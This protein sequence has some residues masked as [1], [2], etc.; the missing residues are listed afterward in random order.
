VILQIAGGQL[1]AGSVDT[2]AGNYARSPITLRASKISSVLGIEVPWE[3]SLDILVRLGCTVEHEDHGLQAQVVPP[4]FRADLSREIDLIEEIARIHGYEQIPEDASVPLVSS[5]RRPKDIMMQTVRTVAC[6]AGLDE[7]L[8]P[9]L[10]SKSPVSM[11][12]PWTADET[13][14]TMVPLLEGASLLRRSLIPSLI[15]ARL[16]NQSQSNRDSQLFETANAYLPQ[17]NGLPREQF[18]IGVIGPADLRFVVGVF[19]EILHRVCGPDFSQ[20]RITKTQPD[21]GY[22]ASKSG[23]AWHVDGQMIAWAGQLDRSIVDAVKLDIAA[24]VGEL[25]L[26]LLLAHARL[27]PQ[28][29]PIVPFPTVERDLNL[30]VD[31]PVQWQSLSATIQNAAGPLCINVVFREIYRDTKKDGEGKKRVL[32]SIHLRSSTETLTSERADAAIE[33]VLE[34]C[35]AQFQ[36]TLLPVK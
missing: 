17:A 27:V 8:T 3:R 2:R 23:V 21:W 4:S 22:I 15:A 26:D 30:I 5:T 34:A 33:N 7:T 11:I 16:Y 6:A 19:E 20:A 12:S 28:L 14:S 24:S 25:N 9:S 35:K 13:L 29:Q 1:L 32:L 18:H 31:E 36:A 10:I